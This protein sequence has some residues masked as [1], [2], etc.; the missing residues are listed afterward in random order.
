MNGDCD[1]Q[2]L[3]TTFHINAHLSRPWL[4]DGKFYSSAAVDAYG[5]VDGYTSFPVA[6]TRRPWDEVILWSMICWAWPLVVN[7]S[8]ANTKVHV[9]DSPVVVVL[10]TVS[11]FT[12]YLSHTF[13]YP[14]TETT[15]TTST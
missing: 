5:A 15:P 7:I 13:H 3:I 2:I 6:Y 8:A 10:V 4:K 14:S 1:D 12:P 11:L 9:Q